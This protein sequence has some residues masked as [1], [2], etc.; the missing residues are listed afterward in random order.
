MAIFNLEILKEIYSATLYKDGYAIVQR[1]KNGKT[2]F[3]D[4]FGRISEQ[5]TEIGDYAYKYMKGDI[6]KRDIPRSLFFDESFRLNILA[7]EIRREKLN[8]I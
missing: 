7:E 1:A 6:Q 3:R 5:P 8:R 4:V 2:L